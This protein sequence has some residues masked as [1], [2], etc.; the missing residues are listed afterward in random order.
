MRVVYLV[1]HGEAVAAP[2][3]PPDAEAALSRAGRRQA[4]AAARLL[5]EQLA[6]PRGATVLVVA[7]D[8]PR[9]VETALVVGKALGAEL[10][11]EERLREFAFPF[12][13]RRYAA[14]RRRIGPE[15]YDRFQKDPAT[16]RL[17]EGE[18]FDAFA[19]RVRQGLAAALRR[20]QGRPLVVVAHDGVN[21]LAELLLTGRPPTSWRSVPAYGLGEVRRVLAGEGGQEER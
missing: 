15:L 9:A 6:G 21:R 2:G 20:A 13:G 16:T 7:S 12:E 17:P 1:R 3:Y 5:A 19:A 14:A 11:L 10:I 4:E 18:P 8:L